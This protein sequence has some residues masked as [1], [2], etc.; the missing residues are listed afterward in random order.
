[1]KVSVF[2]YRFELTAFVKNELKVG[3][4]TVNIPTLQSKYPYL[5]PIKPNVY[6]Y[7]DK[8]LTI[9][10]DSFHAIRPEE[11]FRSEADPNISRVLSGNMIRVRCL[12]AKQRYPARKKKLRQ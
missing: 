12:R 6:N 5:A 1:M 10:Q 2:K 11:Y 8:D 4:D 3:R 9:G 7:A